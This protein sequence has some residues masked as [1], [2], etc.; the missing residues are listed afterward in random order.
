[1]VAY[2]INY[3]L[4]SLQTVKDL[5]ETNDCLNI[6]NVDLYKGAIIN[7]VDFH[8]GTQLIMK[9]RLKMKLD[10]ELT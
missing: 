1:M 4:I 10:S 7:K 2:N 3:Q 5:Q 6:Y 9:L 8:K